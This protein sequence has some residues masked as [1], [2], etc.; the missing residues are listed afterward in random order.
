MKDAMVSSGGWKRQFE[1]AAL[2]L[3]EF[4]FWQGFFS[5]GDVGGGGVVSC[6]WDPMEVVL[7]RCVK[8]RVDPRFHLSF[9]VCL[10]LHFQFIPHHSDG[11]PN[12]VSC[13]RLATSIPFHESWALIDLSTRQQ[14]D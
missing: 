2:V 11:L 7:P 14:P 10:V 5:V 6:C 13:H 9:R 8:R 1:H 3:S 4:E 12:P